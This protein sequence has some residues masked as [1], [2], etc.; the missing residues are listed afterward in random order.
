MLKKLLCL[1]FVAL[2]IFLLSAI[3]ITYPLIFHLGNAAVDL[4]DSYFIAWVMNWN[5]HAFFTNPLS[6]FNA[7]IYYPYVNS[8]AFSESFITSSILAIIPL[9]LIG[10]PIFA[11]NFTLISSIFMVGFSTF[12]LSF[13]ITKNFLASVLSGLILVFSPAFLDKEVHIQ[14][15]SIQWVP[16]SILCFLIF[17]KVFRTRYLFLSLL[18][19]L[20][21]LYNSFL[22]GYFLFSFYFI[23]LL[24]LGLYKRNVFKK[25]FTKNTLLLVIL[26]FVLILP[27]AKPYYDVYKEY[28]GARNIRDSIHFALQPEDLIYPNQQT[29]LQPLLLQISNFKNY[30]RYDEV[31]YGYI[32]LIFSILSVITVIYFIKTIRKKDLMLKSFLTTGIFGLILSFGPALHFNRE[33]IHWPFPIILPYAFFYYIIPGF[34]G[35]RNSERWEILFVFCLSIGIAIFL[36]QTLKLNKKRIIIY[37]FLILAVIAEFNFPM[38]IFSIPQVKD[39]PKVYAWLNS[40]PKNSAYINMPIYNWNS[41]NS[42][43][44]FKREYYSTLN[45]RK[46]VN[47]YSGFSPAKWQR[48]AIYLFNNFPSKNSVFKIKSMNV[49]YLIVNKDEYDFLFSQNKYLFGNG[50]KVI[51]TLNSNLSIKLIKKFDNTYIYSFNK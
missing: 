41:P 45:F 26:T 2:L 5:I 27:L 7:P 12:I 34:K 3:Y 46:S 29:R 18:F 17:T 31:K 10:Q 1:Y 13:Y 15:L 23:Y 47:G 14:I 36:N 49:N 51:Q 6:I 28:D 32:G 44:E 30:S 25:I 37:L 33:T 38:Q 21:Q 20:L 16:L 24:F 42:S 35:F 4:G 11:V 39:F 9:K 50:N 43:A 8:L 22:P 19:F 40:T 48:N